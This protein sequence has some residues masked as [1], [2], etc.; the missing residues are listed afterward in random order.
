MKRKLIAILLA[1]ALLVA[2]LP[3]NVSAAG[4][5][6]GASEKHGYDVFPYIQQTANWMEEGLASEWD[7]GYTIL[8]WIV[9]PFTRVV[10][11]VWVKIKPVVACVANFFD[12]LFNPPLPAFEPEPEEPAGVEKPD[13]VAGYKILYDGAGPA[14]DKTAADTLAA[15]LNQITGGANFTASGSTPPTGADEFLIGKISGENIMALGIDEYLIEP[16]DDGVIAI[17]GGKRGVI[18]GVYKFLEKY[19]DCRW[20][21]HDFAV[22]PENLEAKLV[23][24]EQESY[25]PRLEFRETDWISPRYETY[26]LA[27]GLNGNVY[28]SLEADKGGTFGYNGGMAHTIINNFM[29]PGQAGSGGLFDQHP[30]WYA[31]RESSK[32]RVPKQLCLT[33]PAVLAQMKLEVRAQLADGNG[34]PIVSVTQD[35]NQDYCQCAECKRVDA[36]EGSHM[37]TMLR[38]VNAIADDVKDD[39][40]DA[41]IDTFAYQYTRTPPKITRPRDNVIIRLCSIECCFAHPL[42]DPK[43]AENVKFSSDIKTWSQMCDNLYIWDYTTD[44]SHY[45]CIFPDFGVLQEN[46]KFFVENNVKGIYEEGNY[47][48]AACNSE[49]AE[50]RAYL[51]ARLMWDPYLDYGAEM[52]GFLKHYYGDGWQY[53]REFIDLTIAN[54]GTKC[55]HRKLGIGNSPTDKDLLKLKTNQIR[56]ADQ[57]WEKAIELAGDIPAGAETREQRVR[58]SQLSWRFWVGSNKA[59][60]F[61]RLQPEEIWQAANEQLYNDF[62]AFG[63]TQYREGWS[64]TSFGWRFLPEPPPN[65]WGTPMDWHG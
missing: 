1:S 52:N 49:F 5:P 15:V 61:S 28:R 30:D 56:Y 11:T 9:W 42:N 20:Y 58:R 18:Y 48:A 10:D 6:F 33:N 63:I 31:Y 17:A 29:V 27:N 38:F 39:Y 62:K 40:P 16:G 24:V 14:T 50:L 37:G 41:L 65:W 43:C 4:A 44:Y 3:L 60:A 13:S 2:A 54:A 12:G 55:P 34:Q 26:S 25:A 59:A 51:L 19:F 23:A 35:D 8:Y 46:M 57:L 36:E 53:L 22:I 64:A 32:S 47:Q 7:W 21:T 45:N